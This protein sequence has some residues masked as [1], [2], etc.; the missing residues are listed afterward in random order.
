MSSA[1]LRPSPELN[2]E[3]FLEFLDRRP[4][5]RWELFQGAPRA[6]VGSTLAHAT[7]STNIVRALGPQAEARGYRAVNGFLVQATESSSFEPDALVLCGPF[8]NRSRTTDR[9]LIVFEVLSPSTMDFDR[10]GK[11]PLYRRISS[12]Q[13][14]VFVYQDST[15]V[16]SW[17]RRDEGWTA[18]P[19]LLLDPERSLAL[20]SI[21][22]SLSL[23]D[24]Y[25][26][27]VPYPVIPQR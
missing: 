27:V 20:P 3:G 1:L 25:A 12:L 7:I 14:L 6:M 8:D 2:V 4:E 21:A 13:Q 22:G 26:D 5:E 16:E 15:R 23:T 18:E 10:T 9:P 24:I 17:L 19:D 11:A